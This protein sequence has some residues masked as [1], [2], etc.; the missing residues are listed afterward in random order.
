M[1]E[2]PE[3]GDLGHLL[4]Y[5]RRVRRFDFSGYK[6]SSLSR[7]ISKRMQDGHCDSYADYQDYLEVHP[8]EFG[9]LFNTILINVTSF[10]RDA[11]AWDYVAAEVVPRIV[12]GKQMGEPIRV[13]SAGCASGEEAYSLAMLLCE[14]LGVDQFRA[15]VKIYGTDA[16][17]EALTKARQ[18]NYSMR[19]LDGVPAD[20]I[21]RYFDQGNGGTGSYTFRSDLRR[22]V[23]FGRHDLV[24]DAPISRL[25]LLLCRNTL[26]YFNAETHQRILER[27]NFALGP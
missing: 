7:R 2:P 21:E 9:E 16:D 18:A 17:E 4:D 19:E 15:R 27:F 11:A 5:I 6:R 3:N 8:N 12:S 10:F 20:Y 24:Q 26:M 13:W 23:I 22:S 14:V 25:D 1:S